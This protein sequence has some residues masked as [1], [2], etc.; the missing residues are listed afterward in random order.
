[1]LRGNN[2]GKVEGKMLPIPPCPKSKGET[3]EGGITKKNYHKRGITKNGYHKRGI[4]EKN[5]RYRIL[6]RDHNETEKIP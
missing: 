3:I 6:A 1:M 4:T 2:K 5:Y